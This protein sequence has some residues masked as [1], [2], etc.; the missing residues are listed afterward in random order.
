MIMILM[1]PTKEASGE[2][3]FKN[4]EHME[5]LEQRVGRCRIPQHEDHN[6]KS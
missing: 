5:A 2:R 4:I 6:Q 1:E 3:V